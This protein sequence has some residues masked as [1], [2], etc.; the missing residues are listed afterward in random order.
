M[1]ILTALLVVVIAGCGG[2]GDVCPQYVVVL[3]DPVSGACHDARPCD[4]NG[5][6]IPIPDQASCGSSCETLSEADCVVAAGCRA[7]YLGGSNSFLGCWGTAPSGP[8]ST[9]AC[10][11]LDAQT[12]SRHDNCSAWYLESSPGTT[13]F[14][15]CADEVPAAP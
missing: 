3:R 7:A 2:G 9:G 15:H 10:A 4:A 6:E 13:K 14:D 1:R 12:C 5:N 8:V 11:G